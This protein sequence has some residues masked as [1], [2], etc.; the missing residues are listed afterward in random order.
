MKLITREVVEEIGKRITASDYAM[1]KEQTTA[2]KE[3]IEQVM[4]KELEVIKLVEKGKEL[5]CIKDVL[6]F[7]PGSEVDEELLKKFHNLLE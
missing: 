7:D 5:S 6:T 1:S 2:F 4:D 3:I